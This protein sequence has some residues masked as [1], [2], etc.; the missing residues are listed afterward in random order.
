MKKRKLTFSTIAFAILCSILF[1]TAKVD[2]Q[3]SINATIMDP[4]WVVPDTIIQIDVTDVLRSA[5]LT[6]T[7]M[8]E[9]R[10]SVPD[11]TMMAD[12]SKQL[13]GIVGT[14]DTIYIDLKDYDTEDIGA[15]LLQ[16][17]KNQLLPMKLANC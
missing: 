10:K 6:S 7:V 11:S 14:I 3:S 2:A 15:R 12:F 5:E 8:I 1:I 13:I 17:Y 16:K 9:L 4:T